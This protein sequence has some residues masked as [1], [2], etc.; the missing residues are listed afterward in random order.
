[1]SSSR[2]LHYI[3]KLKS[4]GKIAASRNNLDPPD[5]PDNYTYYYQANID[6]VNYFAAVTDNNGY[7]AGSGMRL[8][9]KL[10]SVQESTLRPI[11]MV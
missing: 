11:L 1:M 2:L 5:N 9:M 6:G 10:N 8:S 3:R 7:E 4:D